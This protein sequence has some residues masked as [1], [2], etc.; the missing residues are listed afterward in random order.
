MAGGLCLPVLREY[1][2]RLFRTGFPVFKCEIQGK[3]GNSDSDGDFTVHLS[4][5]CKWIE[6]GVLSVAQAHLTVVVKRLCKIIN[7]PASFTELVPG[8]LV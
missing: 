3:Q 2:S 4:V 7:L 6:A 5:R 1:I 8:F